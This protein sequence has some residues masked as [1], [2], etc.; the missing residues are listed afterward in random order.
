MNQFDKTLLDKITN[1]RQYLNIS[2]KMVKNK[3]NT[4]VLRIKLFKIP[5]K[6]DLLI[7]SKIKLFRTATQYFQQQ[8]P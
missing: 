3:E 6:Q 7:N 5:K 4:Q 2:K 1:Q 8:S